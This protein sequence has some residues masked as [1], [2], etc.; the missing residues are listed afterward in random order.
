VISVSVMEISA[1]LEPY[2]AKVS[3]TVLRG[4]CR[5]NVVLLPGVNTCELLINPVRIKLPKLLTGN[6]QKVRGR[7]TR[8]C[9]GLR[10]HTDRRGRSRT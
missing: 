4:R 3:R 6:N 1:G 8:W 2:E 7:I 5:S 9:F 10:R